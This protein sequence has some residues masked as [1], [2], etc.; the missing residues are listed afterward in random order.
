M[1]L[2]LKVRERFIFNAFNDFQ[3]VKR[4]EK[5]VIRSIDSSTSRRVLNQSES[6]IW[7]FGS[8]S[9]NYGSPLCSVQ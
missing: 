1:V 5:G 7:D 2:N 6:C 4:F 3:P 9:E 8:L